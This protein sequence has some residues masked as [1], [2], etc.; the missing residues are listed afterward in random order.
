MSD[1]AQPSPIPDSVNLPF[2]EALYADYLRN[3]SAVPREWQDY[4]ALMTSGDRATEGRLGPSFRPTSIFN[5]PAPPNGQ[6]NGYAA[7][8]IHDAAINQDRVDQLIRAHRVRGHIMAQVDPLR[9]PKPYCPELKPYFYGFTAAD[10]NRP[11]SSR[12]ISGKPVRTLREIL[13]LM[14][15]TYCRT[16]GVQFM[17]IDSLDVRHWLQERMESTQN[18]LK[19]TRDEQLRILT[20]L[21]D[22]VIFEEFIQKKFTGAK[23]F[24]LEGAESL[25]PLLDLAIE[26]AGHQGVDEVVI[27]MAHRG[28]LN[29]LANIMGMS[30][31]ELFRQFAEM[32]AELYLGRGDVKYHLGYAGTWTTQQGRKLHLALCFNPSHLEYVNPVVL[33]RVRAMQDRLGDRARERSLALLVHGDAAFAGEGIVQE[34]LNLSELEGYRVGGCLHVIVNNQLGFTTTPREGRSSIYA[35]DVAKMLQ[36]P[37]FHVNGED[38]EA[39]AQVVR[40]AL[41]FRREFKRDVVIDMYAYRRYGHNESDEP[42][43]TQ[44]VLYRRIEARKSVREGYLDYLLSLGGVTRE[45]ADRIA[46]ERREWLESELAGAR[47]DPPP[48]L[49]SSTT[50]GTIWKHYTGGKDADTPQ[51]DTG[52][53]KARLSELLAAQARTPRGFKVHPKLVRLLQGREQMARGEKPLDWAA[54]EALAFATLCVEGHRVRL[55]GQ[56][57]ARGTYSHRHAVLRDYDTG[58]PYV[59]LQ[60]LHPDQAPFEVFNSPLSEEGV[61][62]FDY[63]FALAYPEALVMWEAQFGDFVNTAQVYIDQFISGAED[64]W[65]SL[66]GLVLLLPH[67][68]EGQG[69]EH[70]SCRLERFLQLCAEDN[71]QV[72]C[73]STPAQMFHLLRRQVKRPIRKPLVALTPKSFLRHPLAVS[74]LDELA[75]GRFQHVLP[76]TL[77]DP[78]RVKAVL[79]CMGKVYYELLAEREKRR[80][81]DVALVRVEQFYPL[82]DAQ[83]AAGLRG[84]KDGT[85]VFWTQEEPLNMGAAP[86]FK[87]RYH[88]RLL[89]RYPLGFRGRPESSS[90]ATGSSASFKLEQTRLMETAFAGL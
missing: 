76:D 35:T 41:D 23:R 3:P 38:P 89:G 81:M 39:V 69:P 34:T 52:V 85:P 22:A 67:G 56:D 68:Q 16:I 8:A 70:S 62:G 25:M 10:L 27:G 20:R 66:N 72:C 49:K 45:E 87:L 86:Y 17:H 29:T 60:H 9:H 19:L 37:V 28:R 55:S 44:P 73:P 50:L 63:G 71:M 46:R 43:F 33:G 53:P 13:F 79:M 26:H 2:V 82:T 5:P 21:T 58:E 15:N 31:R 4:F 11:F 24:S 32:D 75:T 88:D 83:L 40:L 65:F 61:L 18:R 51:V 36:S 77:V 6:G 42:S 54:G 7:P 59:P 80:R 48:K 30:P 64:K 84:I 90:P 12:T 78:A 14:R 47:T 57:S 74:S 1:P